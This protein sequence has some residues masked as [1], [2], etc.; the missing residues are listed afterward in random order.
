M[1]KLNTSQKLQKATATFMS[2]PSGI[3][4]RKCSSCGNHTIAGGKCEECQNK[5]P[6]LQRK[7]SNSSEQ[8]EAPPIVHEVLNS[9]GQPLD[10]TT[11]AF[12]ETRFGHDFSHVRVHMNSKAAEAARAIQAS[13]FT[14]GRNIIFGTGRYEPETSIGKRLL[15]HELT[16]VVQQTSVP[17]MPSSRLAIEPSDS[18]LELEADQTA[19]AIGRI[20]STITA[21]DNLPKT[22]SKSHYPSAN[23]RTARSST[24]QRQG[25]CEPESTSNQSEV[26]YD[27]ENQVCRFAE[28]NEIGLSA[29]ESDPVDGEF[30]TIPAGVRRGARPVLDDED[31]GVVI[32]FRYSSGGYYEIYDLEGTFIESGEP[33]LES[34]LIDPIDI[35][36][37]GITGL[38][39]GLLRG[40][41]R[42]AIRGMAGGAGRG[43]GTGLI[44]AGLGV[45][46]RSLSQRA[47]TAVRGAYR[48][49]RFRGLLNFTATTA[50]RMA[51][52]SRRVPHHILKLA[53][54]FGSRA[55]D[56]QGAAGAFRYVIPMSRNGSQYTLEVVIR[57]ADRTVL[58]FLYR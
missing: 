30:W 17:A 1:S 18:L 11:R 19:E 26:V 25:V 57:E 2:A 48:A 58:H 8:S 13:A 4:Q 34:S 29:P 40:G 41:G 52:P 49:I 31:T 14:F 55:P 15:A 22:L 3:L 54:R 10:K 24:I 6:A 23:P 9:L 33:G 20:N 47:I 16:H 43:G 50:A 37:G 21:R 7:S 35:L 56:P 39:R 53:L 38:G 12:F 36:A 27:Y 44:R 42:A 46:I 51:D 32:A 45:A 5:G 28:P